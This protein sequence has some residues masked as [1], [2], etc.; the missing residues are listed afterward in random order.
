[1]IYSNEFIDNENLNN[2][3]ITNI[4]EISIKDNKI[5]LKLF[6]D[7]FYKTYKE[8]SNLISKEQLLMSLVNDINHHI[9]TL[10]NQNQINNE[11]HIGYIIYSKMT[12]GSN[13]MNNLL[14]TVIQK[15]NPNLRIQSH[16]EIISSFNGPMETVNG[17]EILNF[18]KIKI[19]IIVK[20]NDKDY[21]IKK[22][23][24]INL[25]S[26]SKSSKKAAEYLINIRAT[27]LTK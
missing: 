4:P 26:I 15:N 22:L 20:P 12:L 2:S 25:H 16:W 14:N 18:D 24:D 27:Q 9:T 6:D 5:E 13:K 11:Y 8:N 10:Y 21:A 23:A 17:I 7:K 1:M 19:K 3:N